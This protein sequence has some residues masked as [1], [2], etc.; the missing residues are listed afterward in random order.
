MERPHKIYKYEPFTL[1]A[2]ENLK[3]CTLY[4]GSPFDFN[5]P[6]D[7]AI[8]AQLAPMSDD[9]VQ[10]VRESFLQDPSVPESTKRGVAKISVE[11]LREQITRGAKNA[12]DQQRDNFLKTRG[13]TCFSECN[14]NLLMWSHYGDKYTGFCL[15]FQT[16]DEPF[17]LLRK[18]EYVEHPPTLNTKDIGL[19]VGHGEVIDKLFCTK[20]LDWEYEKE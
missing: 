8:D 16:N 2:V 15:E 20:H 6:F 14:A 18:V 11:A 3:S 7:C 5:D 4:F 13:V 19:N 12:I 9:E 10:A 1:Q 17:S